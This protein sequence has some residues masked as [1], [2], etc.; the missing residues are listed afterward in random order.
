MTMLHIP[1]ASSS[2]PAG[3]L[4][5]RGRPYARRAL[6]RPHERLRLNPASRLAREQSQRDCILQP[7][8]ASRRATLDAGG[9]NP[10]PQRGCI[11]PSSIVRVGAEMLPFQGS[12]L[13]TDSAQGSSQARNPGQIDGIPLGFN[14]GAR[15]DLITSAFVWE[16]VRPHP[17]PLPQERA[18]GQRSG[19]NDGCLPRLTRS[20]T[21]PAMQNISTTLIALPL[22]GE[23]VGVRADQLTQGQ[24]GHQ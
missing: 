21:R 5:H 9:K 18:R 22:L 10:Q 23:R 3:P 24:H 4:H 6:H 13:C 1:L 2:H 7:R 20:Q 8:V 17:N 15:L 19:S 16:N 12:A 11:I 14:E